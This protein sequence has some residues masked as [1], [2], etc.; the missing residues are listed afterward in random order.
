M[1]VMEQILFVV[2]GFAPTLAA[3]QAAWKIA[4]RNEDAQLIRVRA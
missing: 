2:L 1:C 4:N 3:L